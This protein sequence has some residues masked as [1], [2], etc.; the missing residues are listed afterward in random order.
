MKYPFFSSGSKTVFLSQLP[1]HVK[2]SRKLVILSSRVQKQSREDRICCSGF[3]VDRTDTIPGISGEFSPFVVLVYVFLTNEQFC[4]DVSNKKVLWWEEFISISAQT[5]KIFVW[6]KICED[7]YNVFHNRFFFFN[8]SLKSHCI[9]YLRLT[10][11]FSACLLNMTYPSNT[12]TIPLNNQNK[13][14]MSPNSNIV[15]NF[16]N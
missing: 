10:R 14:K 5:E 13:N 8:H 9:K 2:P 7:F 3:Y 16:L 6:E 12:R 4:D 11:F 1:C 15:S